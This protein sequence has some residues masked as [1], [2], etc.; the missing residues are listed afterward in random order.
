MEI[1]YDMVLTEKGKNK[2]FENKDTK[3]R[4]ESLISNTLIC[5]EKKDEIKREIEKILDYLC[6]STFTK[7]ISIIHSNFSSTDDENYGVIRDNDWSLLFS[8]SDERNINVHELKYP[9][10]SLPLIWKELKQTEQEIKNLAEKYGR[11]LNI[12][13]EDVENKKRGGREFQMDTEKSIEQDLLNLKDKAD[14]LKDDMSKEDKL[15]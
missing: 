13:K 7:N 3:R 14:E 5:V 1:N 2:K 12:I 15:I 11:F 9:E 8:V 4:I 10:I 6:T